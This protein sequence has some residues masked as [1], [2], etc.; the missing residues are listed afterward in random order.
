MGSYEISILLISVLIIM[1]ISTIARVIHH[2]Y[3]E[4]HFKLTFADAPIWS[5]FYFG[6]WTIIV[7]I[8]F[9]QH[10]VYLFGSISFLGYISLIFLLLGVFPFI[11]HTLRKRIGSP[12]WLALLFPGQGMLTLE[13]RYIVAKIGD[14]I[15]QQS[16][17]GVLIITLA[18]AGVIYPH[19]VI[20]F[21]LLFALAHLYIFRTAGFFWGMHYT[22]YATLSG[23]AFPFLILFIPAGIAYTIILHMLFYV[24]SAAFFAKMP[25]PSNDSVCHE[26]I[27]L[28]PGKAARH[29]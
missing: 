12:K 5:L 22:A 21:V 11:Y 18:S 6:L 3:F 19:I 17:A 28:S 24:L 7:T 9:P 23:F 13:E 1:G 8:L 16:I 15:F 20:I 4:K 27:G 26:C 29:I 14:V 25:L 2:I 10:M